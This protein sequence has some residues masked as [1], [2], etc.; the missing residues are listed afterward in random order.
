MPCFKKNRIDTSI[1]SNDIEWTQEWINNEILPKFDIV[2]EEVR[3]HNMDLYGAVGSR[4]IR[5]KKYEINKKLITCVNT[6]KLSPMLKT[7]L[8]F[9]YNIY[10]TESSHQEEIEDYQEFSQVYDDITKHSGF[11]TVVFCSGIIHNIVSDM[12]GSSNNSD[13]VIQVKN[14]LE[15]LNKKNIKNILTQKNMLKKYS[16]YVQLEIGDLITYFGVKYI[17]MNNILYDK[18]KVEVQDIYGYGEIKKIRVQDCVFIMT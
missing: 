2:F 16:E 13:E 14:Q 10:T 18:N 4:T 5:N 7:F 8:G 15:I 12:F 1:L 9:Y 6:G 17:K 3:E 11:D